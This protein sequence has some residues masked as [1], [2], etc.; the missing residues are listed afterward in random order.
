MGMIDDIDNL[1]DY[2]ER[3]GPD[4]DDDISVSLLRWDNMADPLTSDLCTK[5]AGWEDYADV[6]LWPPKTG[7]DWYYVDTEGNIFDIDEM[8][9][10]EP[11]WFDAPD[12][13][14]T[15]YADSQGE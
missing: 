3:L 1:S 10:G 11:D 7:V 9:E 2:A 5:I 14:P 6:A 15:W 13:P 12:D 8:V 4:P